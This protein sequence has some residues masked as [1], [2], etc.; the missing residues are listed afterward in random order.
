M[1]GRSLMPLRRREGTVEVMRDLLRTSRYGRR[2]TALLV[3]ASLSA[4]LVACHGDSDDNEGSGTP[5][6]TSAAPATT[7]SSSDAARPDSDPSGS[8]AACGVPSADASGGAESVDSDA[9]GR[10]VTDTYGGRVISV[11]EDTEQG[12]P[13]WEVEATGGRCGRIEVDVDK[14]SG[15]ILS[16]EAED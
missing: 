4:V 13:A 6:T 5:A 15:R 16:F 7:T 8:T 11:E 14:A 12:K 1:S 10:I 2:F 9:A 3:V